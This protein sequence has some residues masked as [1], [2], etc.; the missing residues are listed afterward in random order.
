MGTS[1]EIAN[2]VTWLASDAA[3]YSTAT[4]FVIDGGMMQFS[5]GL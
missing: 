5:P 1:A 2:L 3:S 4:T